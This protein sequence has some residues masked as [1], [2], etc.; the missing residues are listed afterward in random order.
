MD[1]SFLRRPFLFFVRRGVVPN[2]L[3]SP[4]YSHLAPRYVMIGDSKMYLG[5]SNWLPLW[6]NGVYEPWTT[7]VLTKELKEGDVFVDVGANIGFF[8]LLA[9][10]LVGEKGRVYA[11]EP[12]PLS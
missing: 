7:E 2:F 8:T 12:N 1:K 6:A 5:D 10:K 9:S 11:F 3:S 4:L